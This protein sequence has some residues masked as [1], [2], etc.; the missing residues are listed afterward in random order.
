MSSSNVY[1]QMITERGPVVGEGLLAGWEGSVEIKDF[2]W[3]M[4]V[5]KD[6]DKAKLGLGSSMASVIGL[7]KTVQVR[8][9]PLEFTKRFDVSSM[10]MHLCLDR[11]WKVLTTTIT[12]LYIKQ[13]GQFMHE[14]GFVLTCSD[15][16]F[17]E[18]SL[19]LAQDGNM[20]E[21]VETCKLNFKHVT[22]TYLI[23]T[24]NAVAPAAPF[25]FPMPSLV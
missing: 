17:A 5:N 6:E 7:G 14:P 22:M 23:K 21:L 12:V 10:Q 4:H 3:G 1:M 13:K 15:G 25:F 20:T 18:I 16:Y 9:E 8:L 11:H 19:D 2:S 24:P